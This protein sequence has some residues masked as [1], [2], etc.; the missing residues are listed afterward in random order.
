M[1]PDFRPPLGKY[2]GRLLSEVV[3]LDPGYC[4]WL[5][6]QS[7]LLGRYPAISKGFAELGVSGDQTPLHNALQALFLDRAVCLRLIDHLWGQ[8]LSTRLGAAALAKERRE[9]VQSVIGRISDYEPPT[10]RGSLLNQIVNLKRQVKQLEEAVGLEDQALKAAAT[11]SFSGRFGLSSVYDTDVEKIRR[12]IP[13]ATQR[14]GNELYEQRNQLLLMRQRLS[15][16]RAEVDSIQP[17][18]IL[19]A[20]TQD[21]RRM[22]E[23]NGSDVHFRYTLDATLPDGNPKY[24]DLSWTFDVWV[25]IKPYVGDDYPSVLRQLELQRKL[26]SN[27]INGSIFAVVVGSYG[28]HGAT[29]DQVRQIFR[30]SGFRLVLLEEIGC[31]F[32]PVT[33]PSSSAVAALPLFSGHAQ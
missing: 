26:A 31:S 14:T 11:R 20:C 32:P 21:L 28:G 7:D 16:A 19:H 6:Q 25:E 5:Q 23:P 27:K 10:K 1:T 13:Y 9:R 12:A 2:K 24:P 8:K 18:A 30:E 29:L 22:E 17:S 33:E 15:V 4:E 3:Y